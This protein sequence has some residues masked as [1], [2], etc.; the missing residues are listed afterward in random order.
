MKSCGQIKCLALVNALCLS[1]VFGLG[2]PAEVQAI[3]PRQQ[4]SNSVRSLSKD[5]DQLVQAVQAYLQ[6]AGRWSPS[7]QGKDMQLCQALQ[8]FQKKVAKLTSDN[9]SQPYDSVHLD[10]QLLQFQSQAVGQ[11]LNS[12][13]P[14]PV[15][16]AAWMQLRNDMLAIG[17]ALYP[18]Q[19][20]NP[21]NFY[22]MDQGIASGSSI[23]STG[24]PGTVAPGM[25]PFGGGRPGGAIPAETGTSPFGP[26]PSTSPFY[27]GLGP[28]NI[29]ITENSTFDPRPSFQGSYN[30]F[31]N[32]GM[33]NPGSSFSPGGYPGNSAGQFSQAMQSNLNGADQQTERFVKQLTT[34]LQMKGQWPPAQGSNEMNL[35]QN[36]QAFQQQLRKVKSDMQANASY[37]LIQTEMRQLGAV[38]QSIDQALMQVGAGPDVTS[39]WNEVRTY[40]NTA[41]QSFY[42]G[43]SG[44][45]MWMR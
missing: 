42:S 23:P 22:D 19:G 2:I 45:Y 33:V 37:S 34:Y 7:P 18:V 27:P 21:G 35:C 38:S 29:N 9:R 25:M 24:F 41:Y 6:Q 28:T 3:S 31:D 8:E 16:A 13:T 10:L 17:Q 11:L 39:R 4:V 5:T 14:S 36:V 40:M 20:F 1:L 26:L 44:G 32:F 12:Q 15:V 43:G 30:N